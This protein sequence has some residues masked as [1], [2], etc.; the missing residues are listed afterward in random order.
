MLKN[1]VSSEKSSTF[2]PD[3]RLRLVNLKNGKK[4]TKKCNADNQPLTEKMQKSYLKIWSVQKKAV[5]LQPVSRLTE[6]EA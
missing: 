6:K 4:S 3:L 1:L 5:P 2:A